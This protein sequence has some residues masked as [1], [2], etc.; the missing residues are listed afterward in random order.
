[1]TR[2]EW[3]RI[4][5]IAAAVLAEPESARPECLDS[6]CR[7]D[8]TLRSEVESLLTSTIQAADLYE[9]PTL[10]MRGAG[11]ALEALSELDETARLGERVGAYRLIRALGGGGMGTAYLAARADDAFQKDVAIKLIKRGMDTAAVLRRFRHERQILA[12]LD[13][14]NIARLL[15]GGTTA[16]GLP[17]FVMEYVDGE[18]LDQ[19]SARR[20]LTIAE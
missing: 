1:M 8:P 17:Y 6:W 7:S 9:T 18:P 15:D 19:Y 16:D 12:G 20:A 10:L 14:P 13:H 3:Q 2:G 4:K 11:A 5:D